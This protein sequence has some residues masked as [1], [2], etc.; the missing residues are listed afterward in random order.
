MNL[1]DWIPFQCCVSYP[2]SQGPGDAVQQYPATR[3]A[4]M[5]QSFQL[6]HLATLCQ[7][8]ECLAPCTSHCFQADVSLPALAV[9]A[10]A[11][12]TLPAGT[13]PP[14]MARLAGKGNVFKLSHLSV[15]K[16]SLKIE[17]FKVRRLWYF[18]WGP[19]H[20]CVYFYKSENRPDKVK[21]IRKGSQE[22]L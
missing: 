15:S 17:I 12:L 9:S 4:Q 5:Q 16:M 6:P 10:S 19:T 8:P 2:H 1:C 22:R 18:N 20:L 13:H 14:L 21:E 11:S 3:P 7:G